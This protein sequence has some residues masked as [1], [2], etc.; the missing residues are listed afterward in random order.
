MNNK[1]SRLNEIGYEGAAKIVEGL[2]I[3]LN[4]I[5]LNIDFQ[6]K[7]SILR[8]IKNFISKIKLKKRK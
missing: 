8:I 4:L 3:L 2:S 6:L 7:F 5:T 1:I